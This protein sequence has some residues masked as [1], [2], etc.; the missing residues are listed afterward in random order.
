[1]GGLIPFLDDVAKVVKNV[2][3]I[4]RTLE[5]LDYAKKKSSKDKKETSYD[6]DSGNNEGVDDEETSD[7]DYDWGDP[8]TLED[9]YD[10]HAADFGSASEQDYAREANEFYKNRNNY[11]VKVDSNGTTR[12]YDSKTNSFGSYNSDGTTKTYFKPKRGKNYWKGQPGN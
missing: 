10:R 11:K 7:S 8:D 6:N 2:V 4:Y 3:P 12:V 5:N 1:M 9:H